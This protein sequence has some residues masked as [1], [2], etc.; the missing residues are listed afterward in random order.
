V[1]IRWG[2]LSTGLPEPVADFKRALRRAIDNAGFTNLGGL[3]QKCGVPQ[4]TLSDAASRATM[5]DKVNLARIL[6]AC[7]RPPLDD[8]RYD[9]W[10]ALYDCACQAL[11][12]EP[13][14]NGTA[15]TVG[16]PTQQTAPPTPD[17]RAPLAVFRHTTTAHGRS[18]TTEIFIY[19][20]SGVQYLI[21]RHRSV[22][23]RDKG[24]EG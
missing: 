18:E 6:S 21:D 22:D 19:S 14:V 3:V 20:D 15:S 12:S 7:G 11:R 5:P 4:S 17:G 24:G 16:L 2:R 23:P 8:S 1:G 10:I 9:G 13:S